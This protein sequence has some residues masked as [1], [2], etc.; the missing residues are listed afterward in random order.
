MITPAPTYLGLGSTDQMRQEVYRE[1][2]QAIWDADEEMNISHTY[3]IGDPDWVSE[4]YRNLRETLK[5]KRRKIPPPDE[6]ES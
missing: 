1:M 6:D 2:V 4:Q 5:A 3:F